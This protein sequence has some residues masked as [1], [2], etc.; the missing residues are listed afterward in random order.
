M[1]CPLSDF[2]FMTSWYWNAGNDVQ[3]KQMKAQCTFIQTKRLFN[4][5]LFDRLMYHESVIQIKQNLKKKQ[6]LKIKLTNSLQYKC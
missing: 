6:G 2:F 1:R 5:H 3:R 4:V